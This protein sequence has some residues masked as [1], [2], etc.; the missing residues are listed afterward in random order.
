MSRKQLAALAA[1][2]PEEFWTEIMPKVAVVHRRTGA[3]AGVGLTHDKAVFDAFDRCEVV[4]GG[5][6]RIEP[7]LPAMRSRLMDASL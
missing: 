6:W 2:M 7:W 1:R 5:D 4:L 3:V